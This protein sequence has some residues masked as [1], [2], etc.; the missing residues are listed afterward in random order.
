MA[1]CCGRLS[2]CGLSR[3]H[4]RR[5]EEARGSD[6]LSRT[7]WSPVEWP[8]VSRLPVWRD[9]SPPRARVSPRAWGRAWMRCPRRRT[10]K[11]EMGAI[12]NQLASYEVRILLMKLD[13]DLLVTCRC[14]LRCLRAPWAEVAVDEPLTPSAWPARRTRGVRTV[15]GCWDAD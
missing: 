4:A 6:A 14:T 2:G 9:S 11:G 15:E 5:L 13:L 12:V 10:W 3:C 1:S 8:V 7:C